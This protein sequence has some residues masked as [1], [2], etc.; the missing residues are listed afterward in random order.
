[1]WV[2]CVGG[3]GMVDGCVERSELLLL[4]SV[5]AY[6]TIDGMRRIIGSG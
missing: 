3:D 5:E 6:C 2:A 1:M 4:E